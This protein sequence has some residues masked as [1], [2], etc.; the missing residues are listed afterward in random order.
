MQEHLSVGGVPPPTAPQ[1]RG[2]GG[3][4]EKKVK[5]TAEEGAAPAAQPAAAPA[6][7]SAAVSAALPAAAQPA[8]VPAAASGSRSEAAAAPRGQTG[9]FEKKGT[10]T[11]EGGALAAQPAAAQPAA[12][13]AAAAQPATA[14]PAAARPAA[15]PAAAQPAAMPAAASGSGSE[16][17]AAASAAEVAALR[18]QLAK[19]E[20]LNQKLTVRFSDSC[21]MPFRVQPPCAALWSPGRRPL[22]ALH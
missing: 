2:L 14:Q 21:D 3:R 10:V 16:A 13:P 18:E 22:Y 9:R 12:L 11:A 8:A 19:S 6:A 15:L 17:A 5:V 7:Q 4:F 20:D 1:Q